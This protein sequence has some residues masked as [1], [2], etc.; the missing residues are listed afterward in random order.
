[1]QFKF[2]TF[3]A[4]SLCA[5]LLISE[6]A[7]AAAISASDFTD[8]ATYVSFENLPLNFGYGEPIPLSINGVTFTSS[9]NGYGFRTYPKSFFVGGTICQDGCIM[10]NDELDF[11]TVTLPTPVAKVGGSVGVFNVSGTATAEFYSG[12]ALL[13]SLIISSPADYSVF[14]GWDAGA[15]I[16]TSVRFTDIENQEF[17]LTLDKFGYETVTSVP[18]P[19]SAL[20]LGSGL[21]GLVAKR[22]KLKDLNIAK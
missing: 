13:G 20:L 5:I 15:N 9:D 10:T 21:L 18:I 1:M 7:N 16:I 3:F 19:S 17:T 11:I 2:G 14:A 4:H 8:A 22:R 6:G 12:N